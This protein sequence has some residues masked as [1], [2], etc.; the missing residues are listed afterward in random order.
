MDAL[1][2]LRTM[3]ALGIVLGM[4]AGAL[5]G[6]RRFDIK[7]PGRVGAH[8]SRRLAIV[9]RLAIDAKRS[10]ALIR[11]DAEEHLVLLCPEGVIVI[12]TPVAPQTALRRLDPQR[13]APAPATAT[14]TAPAPTAPPTPPAAP[15]WRRHRFP[16]FDGPPTV[17]ARPIV[18]HD[19]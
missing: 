6:V 13:V 2:L 8:A 1:A 11:R 14:A 10:V 17:R 19:A 7:L 9:E 5:W 4:L 15:V 16:A 3:G 18:I 12:E